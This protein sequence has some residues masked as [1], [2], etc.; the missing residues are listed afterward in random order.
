MATIVLVELWKCLESVVLAITLSSESLL[1]QSALLA[2]SAMTRQ[3]RLLYARHSNTHLKVQKLV[4]LARPELFALQS[5]C[6]TI[7]NQVSGVKELLFLK[8]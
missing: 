2:S 5:R 3:L 7:V 8:R 1:V 4:L 6:H